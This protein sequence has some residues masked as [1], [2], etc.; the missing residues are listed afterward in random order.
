M[1]RT[2]PSEAFAPLPA[3]VT[4]RVPLTIH[5]RGWRKRIISPTGVHQPLAKPARID[6]AVVKAP[7]K[8]F[9]WCSMIESGES[10]RK[11]LV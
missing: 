4:V 11:L 8:A 1:K 5:R 2:R 7:A 9:R 10:R 6:N 3:R